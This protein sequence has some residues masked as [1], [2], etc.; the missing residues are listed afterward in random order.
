MSNKM[1]GDRTLI[2]QGTSASLRRPIAAFLVAAAVL[3]GS[4]SGYAQTLGPAPDPTNPIWLS[5]EPPT[6]DECYRFGLRYWIKKNLLDKKAA[7]ACVKCGW[8]TTHLAPH[9]LCW[10]TC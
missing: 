5:A 7:C 1:G 6:P 3:L 4:A 2:R 8:T 10:R 9:R